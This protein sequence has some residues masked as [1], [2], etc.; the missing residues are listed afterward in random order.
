MLYN[1]SNICKGLKIIFK[2]EPH[3]IIEIQYHKP[4]KGASVVR[5]KMRNLI[6]SIIIPQ[7]FRAGEK[8]EKANIYSIETEF[9]YHND[10]TFFFMDKETFE[11]VEVPIGK[12]KDKHKFL[13]KQI[14]VSIYFFQEEI[15]DITI[16]NHITLR[17]SKCEPASK[18]ESSSK[19]IKRA[20][21]ETGLICN[22]PSFININ[23][24]VKIDTRTNT[25]IKKENIVKKYK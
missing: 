11:H 13:N 16:P 7:T 22:V 1:T 10:N 18:R 4:G 25:Y 14:T 2:Q 8:F 24:F 20:E 15:I 5:V 6:N 3:E 17:V 9:L 21:L 12:M 23:D 19:S